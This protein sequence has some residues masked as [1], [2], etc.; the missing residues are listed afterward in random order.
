MTHKKT[1]ADFFVSEKVHPN[2]KTYLADFSWFLIGADFFP[3]GLILS[4][5]KYKLAIQPRILYSA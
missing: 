3:T 4:L 5:H 2:K 1:Q